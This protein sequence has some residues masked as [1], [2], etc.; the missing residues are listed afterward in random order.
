MGHSRRDRLA[1]A[2]RSHRPGRW[3]GGA[4]ELRWGHRCQ[5]INLQGRDWK[6]RWHLQ[7]DLPLPSC[8]VKRRGGFRRQDAFRMGAEI[9]ILDGCRGF[10]CRSEWRLGL[11]ECDGRIRILTLCTSWCEACCCET[12]ALMFGQLL[13]AL[14]TRAALRIRT[15]ELSTMPIASGRSVQK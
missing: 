12:G 5:W 2:R 4:V 11:P 13:M 1:H 6:F 3:T 14:P 9:I 8:Q 15:C 7:G 10:L